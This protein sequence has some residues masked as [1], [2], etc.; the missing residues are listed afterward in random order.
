MITC[1]LLSQNP[2]IF[3][4]QANE[5]GVCINR[6]SFRFPL[7][8][9]P[10]FILS[11]IFSD[12]LRLN[13]AAPKKSTPKFKVVGRHFFLTYPQCPVPKEDLLAHLQSIVAVQDYA[14]GQEKHADG[15]LHLHAYIK[16]SKR[17]SF[18][19]QD[20]FDY[21]THHPNIQVVRNVAA[22]R[23]YVQKDGN[24][25]ASIK[26]DPWLAAIQHAKD[27]N[28]DIAM[29]ELPA[30]DIVMSG[31]KIRANLE[32][33]RVRDNNINKSYLFKVVPGIDGWHRKL[34]TLWLH[35]PSGI[36]KTQYAKSLF[37]NPLIVRHMDQLK[38][39]RDTN[40]GIIFDDMSFA[41]WPREAVI[42]LVDLRDDS[43]LNVKHGH[44]VIPAGLP[45]VIT[46]NVWIWPIDDTNAIRRRV[47]YVNV[48][49]DI[50][51]MT[52]DQKE[53][54]PQMWP[55]RDEPSYFIFLPDV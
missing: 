44:V 51:I 22:V 10:R 28:I 38:Q 20:K 25:I 17:T 11:I 40:D 47:H 15:N 23:Q 54:E 31:N 5:M 48:R 14:I 43:G 4:S 49:E 7:A 32:N 6:T 35:G 55:T 52:D 27:G 34:H 8:Y 13:M 50:R 53:P 30:K 45:R 12:K 33:L 42:H 18:S 36:G 41:H 16:L 21:L 9:K 29:Q 3:L 19:K 46:S 26:L 24:Y 37:N 2:K 39:L 1:Q